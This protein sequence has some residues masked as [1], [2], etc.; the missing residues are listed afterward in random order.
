MNGNATIWFIL[1]LIRDRALL[2]R[3]RSEVE[4]A[5]LLGG[6]DDLSVLN[7]DFTKL[8]SGRLLQSSYAETLRLYMAV[9]LMRIPSHN[10]YILGQWRF[11]QDRLIVMSSR[12]AHHNE[13]IWNT[14]IQEEP[15]P[16]NTFGPI[17]S[18]S[19]PTIL[20]AVR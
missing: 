1:E 6:H 4:E 7:S 10:D 11:P 3:V 13:E 19:T 16:L 18:S 12:T 9:G 2:S 15:H 14:G 17:D 5:M 8:C 20:R